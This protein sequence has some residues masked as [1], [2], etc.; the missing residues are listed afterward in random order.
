MIESIQTS[1]ANIQARR[2][3]IDQLEKL[4]AQLGT[5]AQDRQQLITTYF[6]PK[7]AGWS[8]ILPHLNRMILDAGVK[9]TRKDYTPADKPQYGL[10][11]VKI[12]LPVN[13]NYAN[14]MQLIKNI[15][16]DDKFFII[17]SIDVRG[18]DT[19][20]SQD[21]SMSLNLETF[22]YE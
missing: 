21:V 20:G 8:E 1:R 6:I 15:E 16:N 13:G 19:P 4:N 14:V 17:E 12:S 22:F 10:Y 2:I 7:D 3:R 11:S 9:N 5:S 18:N